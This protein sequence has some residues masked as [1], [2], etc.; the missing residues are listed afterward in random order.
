MMFQIA[1]AE[2]ARNS[3]SCRDKTWLVMNEHGTNTS[4]SSKYFRNIQMIV[5]GLS[6]G[7]VVVETLPEMNKYG[8]TTR[9]CK[10]V[11]SY[12]CTHYVDSTNLAHVQANPGCFPFDV[13]VNGKTVNYKGCIV[14]G[15]AYETD[16]DFPNAEAAMT[17]VSQVNQTQ[18]TLVTSA[19]NYYQTA[20][21][22]KEHGMIYSESDS[23]NAKTMSASTGITL[24]TKKN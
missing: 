24:K 1:E 3:K 22:T 23:A 10:Q 4:S 9:I 11:V 16:C 15:D 7:M 20:I 8:P 12:Y 5:I 17:C 2:K 14:E 21:I 19:Y 13:E 6:I 18:E